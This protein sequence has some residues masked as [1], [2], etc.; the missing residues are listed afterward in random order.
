ME[1]EVKKGRWKKRRRREEEEEESGGRS[2]G[3]KIFRKK[4][5]LKN[6]NSFSHWHATGAKLKETATLK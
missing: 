5:T 6:L 2:K 1:K 3:K 4:K